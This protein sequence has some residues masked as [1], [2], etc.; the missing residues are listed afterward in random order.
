MIRNFSDLGG[1]WGILWLFMWIRAFYPIPM[2]N[3]ILVPLFIF[4]LSTLADVCQFKALHFENLT[5]QTGQFGKGDCYVS[6]S[7]RNTNGLVYRSFLITDAGQFMV[8]NSFGGGPINTDTGSRVFHT[9][10]KAFPLSLKV[11]PENVEVT[12]V[13]GQVL[14][15][16]K[17]L[18]EPVSLSQGSIDIDPVVKPANN[19]GVELTMNSSL[20]LDSGF[21]LGGTPITRLTKMSKFVDYQGDECNVKNNEIF[22]VKDGEV[23]HLYQTDI[24]L[25][26]FLKKR[27]P[28]LDY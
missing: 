10:P 3:L 4:S 14:I 27:C 23:F 19:G 21:R 2:K 1:L 28:Q 24:Q 16:D 5:V 20:L 8:F 6:L 25:K 7:P 9:F 13:T 18:G 17:Y 12:L 15:A 11:N 26:S 22:D